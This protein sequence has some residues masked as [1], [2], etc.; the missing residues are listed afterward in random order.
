ML[1]LRNSSQDCERPGEKE[2]GCFLMCVGGGGAGGELQPRRIRGR[3]RGRL[4]VDALSYCLFHD[5]C[6]LSSS[7][8]G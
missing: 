2:D 8:L 5:Q 1:I 7:G 4:G 6:A 3:I